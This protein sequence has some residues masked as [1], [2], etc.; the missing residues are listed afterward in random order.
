M[1]LFADPADYKKYIN[2]R[3]GLNEELIDTREGIRAFINEKITK[4]QFDALQAE[5]ANKP[6]TDLLS[7][8]SKAFEVKRDEDGNPIE[9]E[10]NV[11]ALMNSFQLGLKEVKEELQYANQLDFNS[12]PLPDIEAKMVDLTDSIN[13]MSK[14]IETSQ[15]N[16]IGELQRQTSTV[17]D[18]MTKIQ[19]VL[20]SD[21]I[22]KPELLVPI[23]E[24]FANLNDKLDFMRENSKAREDQVDLREVRDVAR[25]PFVK[26]TGGRDSWKNDEMAKFNTALTSMN[27][28][29][30]KMTEMATNLDQDVPDNFIDIS[31]EAVKILQAMR[32]NVRARTEDNFN[33]VS[34][35]TSQL[36]SALFSKER[37]DERDMD[38]DDEEVEGQSSS[39]S[40]RPQSTKKSRAASAAQREKL[41]STPKKKRG[42]GITPDDF[43]EMQK[44]KNETGKKQ[45]D[46]P[47]KSGIVHDFIHDSYFHNLYV[48][49]P[50]MEKNGKLVV[51]QRGPKS[52]VIMNRIIDQDTVDLL[53]RKYSPRRKYSD[54]AWEIYERLINLSSFKSHP[55]I[56]RS[57]KFKALKKRQ[58]G[59]MKG[60]GV[61]VKMYKNN[62]ELKDRLKLLQGSKTTGNN[63][64]A[65]D[66]EISEIQA[67]LN[68]AKTTRK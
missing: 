3:L 50:K 29:A 28:I 15:P 66:Q 7:P 59:N 26:Q 16:V 44:M 13:K 32:N 17:V 65:I 5:K 42:K 22:D 53:T 18:Q 68:N 38:D 21:R 46:P 31:V 8:I 2:A 57:G 20:E 49:V 24:K 27:K 64:P 54:R 43:L 60:N 9:K 30:E 58:G 19:E 25:I 45:Y 12:L 4:E 47:T 23:L 10:T 56:R 48:D 6:V 55:N 11:I 39:S 41:K 61:V 34:N 14:A 63:N 35:V 36:E 37:D 1:T 62:K 40:S 33:F 52:S 67:L 51:K